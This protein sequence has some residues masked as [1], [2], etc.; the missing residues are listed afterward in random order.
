MPTRPLLR[1]RLHPRLLASLALA[2]TTLA[3][4]LPAAHAAD[5]LWPTKTVTIVLPSTPGAA[6]DVLTRAVAAELARLTGQAF[7]ID[8]KPGAAGAIALAKL[9]NAA[10]DGYTLSYGNINNL[11]VNP[12]LFKQLAYDAHRDFVPVGPMFTVPNLL[13]VRADAPYRTVADLVAAAKKAP[14]AMSWAASN[15]GS[16][17]HMGGELFKKLSGID[18]RFIPYN[19]DPQ[20]LTDLIGGQLAYTFTNATVAYPMV[21]SGKLRALAIT[22]ASRSALTP[23]VPTLAE[24]GLKGYENGAWGGII[25]PAATP[26]ATVARISEV[27]QA[28]MRSPEVQATLQKSFATPTPGTQQEFSAYIA[29][30]Q[31]KWASVIE[32]AGI[33]KQ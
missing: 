16:S 19:G 17:G 24:S 32:S 5:A 2:C 27:L 20:T 13:V 29:A 4:G 9:K 23:A 31:R 1:F 3:A 11:A 28:A 26:R 10:P 30:E 33:E 22:T 15:L 14:G 7:V 8:N 25:A 12:A 6:S 21:E 18:A